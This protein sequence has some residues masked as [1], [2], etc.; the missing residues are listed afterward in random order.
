M[1][2][3]SVRIM[4]AVIEVNLEL[5]KLGDLSVGEGFRLYSKKQATGRCLFLMNKV[6]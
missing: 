6:I 3:F 1:K 5:F 4:F 2:V